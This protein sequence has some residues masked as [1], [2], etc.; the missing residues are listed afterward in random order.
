MLED[1]GEGKEPSL[2][3]YDGSYLLHFWPILLDVVEL[4]SALVVI[5]SSVSVENLIGSPELQSR[6][7]REA[8]LGKQGQIPGRT[9]LTRILHHKYDGEKPASCPRHFPN[10]SNIGP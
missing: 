9:P 1:V 10:R 3:C 5:L 7:V 4:F 2:S 8:A 6:G